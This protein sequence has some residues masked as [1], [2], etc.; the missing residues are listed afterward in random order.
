[1]HTYM[2]HI[3]LAVYPSIS[4]AIYIHGDFILVTNP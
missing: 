3:N 2:P 1:M 4:L